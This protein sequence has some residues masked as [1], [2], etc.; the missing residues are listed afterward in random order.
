MPK[1]V[2][3]VASGIM[4]KMMKARV[5]VREMPGVEMGIGEQEGVIGELEEEVGRLGGVIG[6][7]GRGRGG[8]GGGGG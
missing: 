5:A 6:G 4:V 1:D 2:S 8:G 7:M 3:T